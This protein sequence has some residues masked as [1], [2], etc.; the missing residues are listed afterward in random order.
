MYENSCF[1]YFRIVVTLFA[2]WGFN[3]LHWW[4]V[5]ALGIVDTDWLVWYSLGCFGFTILFM[6]YLLISGKYANELKRRHEYYVEKIAEKKSEL[7]AKAT[8]IK[9]EQAHADK[10]AAQEERL[11]KIKAA[12]AGAAKAE[13]PVVETA[14]AQGFVANIQDAPAHDHRLLRPDAQQ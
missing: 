11:A 6:A 10:L 4:G 5:F 13:E 14:P 3:A 1:N 9:Q 7:D 2:F 12:G 8:K